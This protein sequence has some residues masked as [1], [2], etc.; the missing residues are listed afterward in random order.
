MNRYLRKEDQFIIVRFNG[1]YTLHDK[2]G[3]FRRNI[4]LPVY[5]AQEAVVDKLKERGFEEYAPGL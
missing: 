5:S 3:N 4:E 2:E 1:S